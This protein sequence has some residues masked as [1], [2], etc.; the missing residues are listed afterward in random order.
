V[1]KTVNDSAIQKMI[2]QQISDG[3]FPSANPDLIYFVFLPSGVTVTQGGSASC[4][5]FC[6]YHDAISNNI[7][8]RDAIPGLFRLFLD[9]GELRCSHGDCFT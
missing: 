5:V 9:L 6:G 2:Q 1:G 7:F 4:K 3:K 8:C